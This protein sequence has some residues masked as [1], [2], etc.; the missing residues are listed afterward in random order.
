MTQKVFPII[1]LEYC[2]FHKSNVL[3]DL[4]S[5]LFQLI[6]RMSISRSRSTLI[7]LLV[8]FIG[9]LTFAQDAENGGP[10]VGGNSG[11]GFGFGFS[12]GGKKIYIY[13]INKNIYNE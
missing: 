12:L 9:N 3:V 1:K 6:K 11:G 5:D 8:F 2:H 4:V 13:L 10:R 7:L